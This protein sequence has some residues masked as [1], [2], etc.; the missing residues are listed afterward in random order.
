MSGQPL[1]LFNSM[2]RELQ[3]FKPIEPGR[4]RLYT[5]GPTVYHFAHL[6]NLRAYLFTDTLRR[7]LQFKGYDVLHVMNIT[8]VGQL[9]SDADEGEDKMEL[10][11]KRQGKTVWEL[12][13][14]YTEHFEKDLQRLN[15][16]PPSVQCKATDHIEEMINF[17]KTCEDRGYAYVVEDGLYFD[18]SKVKDYGKI[19]LL[20]LEGQEGGARVAIAKGK[21]NQADFAV[22]RSSPKDE[23]RQME[24]HSPWGIGAPGWHLECSVMS[25]KY[26]GNKFDIHTG[27]VDHRQVHHCNEIAQNQAFLGNDQ[28][29]ATF[30][31]HNEF[32]ILGSEKMS[33]SSG[34]FLRLQTI[35]DKGIHPLVYR[36]FVLQATYRAQIEFS[37]ET[38]VSA[39]TG[40]SRL[41]KR[42]AQLKEKAA[43]PEIISV[44]EEARFSRGG[45]FNFVI[46]KLAESLPDADKTWIEKLNAPSRPI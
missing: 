30:W 46:S 42:I 33:K 16:S 9:T 14:Y 35:I 3:E 23:K 24:W 18:I 28:T 38:M 26:L 39:R 17:A 27:G 13:Q 36:Y 32:L 5:C 2:G 7:V 45:S 8:D 21:R 12:A 22:W 40:L 37:L 10:S 29:G 34:D 25:I 4:A 43:S 11:A 20:D 19:A 44:A 1:F 41:L 6:G 31:M 15:I